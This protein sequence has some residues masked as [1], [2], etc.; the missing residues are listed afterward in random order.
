M[1]QLL[2]QEEID[3]LLRNI[4][5]GRIETEN[6]EPEEALRIRPYEFTNQEKVTAGRIKT[7]ELIFHQFNRTFLLSL[8]TI[9]KRIVHVSL[10]S[11][12]VMRFGE[13]IKNLPLHSSLHLFQMKPLKGTSL[14]VIE[15]K[16]V[17]ALIDC[18]FGG[19]GKLSSTIEGRDFTTIEQKVIGKIVMTAL[20][21]LEAAWQPIR[22]LSIQY[23][24]SEINPQFLAFPPNESMAVAAIGVDIGEFRGTISFCIPYLIVETIKSVYQLG[25]HNE[26][27]GTDEWTET[28]QEWTD[29][30]RE[31]ILN[32]EV[33]IIVELGKA[34][35][36]IKK[37][38]ELQ[39]GDV[40]LLDTNVGHELMIKVEG[41]PKLK[42]CP[43]AF[44]GN[45]AVKVSS[46]I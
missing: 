29:A 6:D 28:D 14:L 38:L 5:E 8:S 22:S 13:F 4:S 11:I 33:E 34:A 3:T 16:L 30:F 1:E 36:T 23:E 31:F 2:S 37:L 18:F 43:G 32:T 12:D 9:L 40:I 39:V 25:I 10:T 45:K 20:K 21:D 46:W 27:T 15:S 7:L 41:V 42:G 24:R 35:M 44:N 17:F 19:E 26:W